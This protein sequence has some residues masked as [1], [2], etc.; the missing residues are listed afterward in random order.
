MPTCAPVGR[1]AVISSLALVLALSVT[2]VAAFNAKSSSGVN[3]TSLGL[4]LRGHDPM[5]YFT[6][7]KPMIGKPEFVAR[8]DGADYRFASADHRD[9]F[10]KEPSRYVPQYG[11]FCAYAA[12]HGYKADADPKVWKIVNG[13]L[14]VNYNAAVGRSWAESAKPLIVKGDANWPAIKGQAPDALGR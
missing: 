3:V 10:L 11:G 8:H 7:G 5:A 4:A 2:P 12:G 9:A 1:T 14:F 13:R 6:L